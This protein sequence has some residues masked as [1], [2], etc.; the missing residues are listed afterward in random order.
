MMHKQPGNVTRIIA[1][2]TEEQEKELTSL[3]QDQ[4]AIMNDRFHIYF[5]P[6]LG[7]LEGRLWQ[8][9]K[10]WNKPFGIKHWLENKFGFKYG[11]KKSTPHD[12]DIVVL[13][14]PDM[15]I[16]RP[17]IND[18]ST[19][20]KTH[21]HETIRDKELYFKVEHGKPIAKTYPFGNAWVKALKHEKMVKLM[22]EGS[23]AFNVSD[24]DAEV[25]FSVGPPYILTAR[26]MYRVSYYWTKFLPEVSLHFEGMKAELYGYCTAAAHLNLRHQV[27]QGMMVSD[28]NID[29]AEGWEFLNDVEGDACDVVKFQNRVPHVVHFHQ[30]YS[31]GDYFLSKYKI[32]DGIITCDHQLFDLPPKDIAASTNYSR[33]ADGSIVEWTGTKLMRRYRNA[34]MVCSIMDGFNRAAS[35][36]KDHHCPDGANYDATWNHFREEKLQNCKAG[37]D[38]PV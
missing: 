3:H 15:L 9:T 6:E 2:C 10:Y 7:N 28:V 29:K 5:I 35:F 30:R 18:F 14:D 23:P 31:I 37:Q 13:M 22:G 4:I 8:S 11:L 33:F 25:T 1:G 26:D 21:W 24:Y 16:Q 34:F 19:F 32:P 12:D 36:Y 27:S 20:P 17:F 38:C